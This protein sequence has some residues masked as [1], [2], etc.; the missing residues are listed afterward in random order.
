MLEALDASRAETEGML[1][2]Q[3]SFVAD[4]SHELRTPLTSVLAN[5][6]LLADEL[7]GEQG[8]AARAALRSSQRMRRLVADLLL[9]A[10]A[11]AGRVRPHHPTDVAAVVAEAAAELEPVSDGH[12]LTVDAEPA[13]VDGVRDELHRLAVNL[14]ENALR[15]TPPGTR[16]RAE[17]GEHDGEV[18]LAV[19]DDG[20]GV[21][22]PLAPRIFERFVRGGGD[23]AGSS[24]LG[25]AIV[26]AVAESHGGTVALERPASGRGA[27][28]VV[29]M[30]A[31]EPTGRELTPTPA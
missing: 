5:L 29:R 16:V 6:E 28:F 31:A 19:E 20:P 8:E 2:R 7:A 22:E 27:R 23:R 3:R 10:R 13:V 12:E 26:A 17:V 9:L 15:H 25:L 18:T 14:I 30:P 11:D 4:A 24:G 1:V 21:P